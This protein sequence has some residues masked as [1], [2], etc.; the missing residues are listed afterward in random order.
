MLRYTPDIAVEEDTEEMKIW[1]S[2]N[3]SETDLWRKTLAERMEEEVLDK[4]KVEER[5]KR[6]SWKSTKSKRARKVLSKAEVTLGMDKSLQ[7]QEI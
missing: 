1:R 4:Y 5:W 7:K 2:L 3:Q 6:K